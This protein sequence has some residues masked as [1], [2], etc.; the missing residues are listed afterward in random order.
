MQMK[1][2]SIYIYSTA[3]CAQQTSQD[4]RYI[5]NSTVWCSNALCKTQDTFVALGPHFFLVYWNTKRKKK[6]QNSCK[7]NV[8][9]IH[10]G[11]MQNASVITLSRIHC[12]SLRAL[13]I[14]I[15]I[16]SGSSSSE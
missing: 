6:S 11:E 8:C 16:L 13:W 9:C 4:H 7:L 2:N 14:I 1:L 15:C 10:E 12:A 3:A 5:T